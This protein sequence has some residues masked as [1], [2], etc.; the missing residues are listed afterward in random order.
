MQHTSNYCSKLL[1]GKHL[2]ISK[3]LC[4]GRDRLFQLVRSNKKDKQSYL[5]LSK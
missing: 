1:K 2:N 3:S 4:I 5:L